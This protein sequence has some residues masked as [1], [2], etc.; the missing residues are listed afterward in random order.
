[1][2]KFL[3]ASSVLKL[4]LKCRF[5]RKVIFF[6][7][8]QFKSSKSQVMTWLSAQK[9]SHDFD[10]DFNYSGVVFVVDPKKGQANFANTKKGQPVRS[11]KKR[12]TQSVNP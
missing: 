10:F 7:K 3:E 4:S 8:S 6:I 9:K 12:S 5:A 11:T 2:L 1:M